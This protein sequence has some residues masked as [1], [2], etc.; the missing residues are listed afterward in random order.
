MDSWNPR[1]YRRAKTTSE[2][3]ALTQE[4][5]SVNYF[6]ALPIGEVAYYSNSELW[7]WQNGTTI[8]L[9]SGDGHVDFFAIDTKN[10]VMWGEW[11]TRGVWFAQPLPADGVEKATLDTNLK[12]SLIPFSKRE[13]LSQK[14]GSI[15][16]A[17][18]SGRPSLESKF[19]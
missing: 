17:V 5:E 11:N 12:F 2:I 13:F 16:Y 10:T 1:I 6:L 18:E 8:D 19:P 4:N 9:S 15:D 14:R 7:M 3:M